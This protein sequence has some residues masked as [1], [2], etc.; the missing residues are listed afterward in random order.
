MKPKTLKP[1]E[2][3][4]QAGFF[5]WVRSKRDE[6]ARYWLIYAIPNGGLR[7]AKTGAVMKR[8][9]AERGVLDI[10]CQI[11]SRGYNALIIET[12][13]HKGKMSADQEKYFKLYQKYGCYVV[14]CNC[15]KD[16]IE[17]TE[18]YLDG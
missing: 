18:W 1:S 11:A 13:D 3:Q 12:K 17:V 6:D 4:I 2:H 14:V 9:G 7:S 5:R 10:T 8:E 15:L 16:M